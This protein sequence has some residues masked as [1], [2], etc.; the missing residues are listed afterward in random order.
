MRESSGMFVRGEKR[1]RWGSFSHNEKK[2][3]D[4]EGSDFEVD[5]DGGQEAIV[6]DVVRESEQQRGFTN[7]GVSDQQQFEQ[8]VIVLL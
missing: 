7:C 6:K 1:D 4:I 2:S 3:Y 5:T 8:V